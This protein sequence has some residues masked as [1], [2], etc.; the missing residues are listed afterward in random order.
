M[1]VNILKWLGVA[2]GAVAVAQQV[3]PQLPTA[4]VSPSA[5]AVASSIT[6]LVGLIVHAVDDFASA[7]AAPASGAGK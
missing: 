6:A 2:G 3:I 4:G 5:V 7:Q 1:W